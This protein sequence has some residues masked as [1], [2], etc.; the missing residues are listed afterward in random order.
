AVGQRK[1]GDAQDAAE[2]IK[3]PCQRL[4]LLRLEN[5]SAGIGAS[6]A[7]PALSLEARLTPARRVEVRGHQFLRALK[8]LIG[9]PQVTLNDPLPRRTGGNRVASGEIPIR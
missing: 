9:L 1:E 5:R 3:R 4:Q 8:N 7:I 6:G 2:A